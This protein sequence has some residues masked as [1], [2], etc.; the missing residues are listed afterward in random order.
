MRRISLFLS[1][2]CRVVEVFS[3]QLLCIHKKLRGKKLAKVLLREL[4]RRIQ[5]HSTI[6]QAVFALG[7]QMPFNLTTEAKYDV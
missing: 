2:K 7:V 1:I 4:V 6:K 5:L 3:V